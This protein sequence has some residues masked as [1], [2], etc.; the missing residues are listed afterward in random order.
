MKINKS[1]FILYE[2]I[3]L[4]N[5]KKKPRVLMDLLLKDINISDRNLRTMIEYNNKLFNEHVRTLYIAH[6]NQKGY[7]ATDNP[8]VIEKS[9]EDNY[10]RSMTMLKHISRTKKAINEN[11]NLKMDL[12]SAGLFDDYDFLLNETV[13]VSV[14]DELVLT[15]IITAIDIENKMYEISFFDNKHKKRLFKKDDIKK[16]RGDWSDAKCL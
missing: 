6:S 14:D 2:I 10:K 1:D 8:K 11:F 4:T 16:I 9:I 12:E 3:D 15:G 5:W 7:I 13:N